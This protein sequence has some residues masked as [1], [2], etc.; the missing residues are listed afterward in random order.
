ML[1]SADDDIPALVS[2]RAAMRTELR[3]LREGSA[4]VVNLA[5]R[6]RG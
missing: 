5:D 6:R 1:T 4:G 2:E 3:A